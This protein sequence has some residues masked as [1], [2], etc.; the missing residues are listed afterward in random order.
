MSQNIYDNQKFFDGYKKLRD[1]P[2]SANILE[3]KPALF[4][5]AP[6]LKDKAVLDLGC[7]YGENCEEFLRLGA[8]RVAGVDISEKMLDIAKIENPGVEFINADMS[9]LS[10]VKDKYDVVFSS[11]AVHY[12]ENFSLFVEQIFNILT[13][14]GYFIFSQESPLTTA[15]I[16]GAKWVKDENGNVSHYRLTDYSRSGKRSTSWIV[17]GVVKY[18]RTFS[19]IINALCDAGFVI[20]KA[21]E[22]IPTQETINRDPKWEKDLHKPNFLL[23]KA[24]KYYIHKENLDMF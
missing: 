12:V 24:K 14:G 6:D 13:P 4:S 17:D 2:F 23:I 15:P 3:E 20:E 8:K 10:F 22:P 11:L 16:D 18:H 7:G 19:D 21:L 1:N 5:L 9:D